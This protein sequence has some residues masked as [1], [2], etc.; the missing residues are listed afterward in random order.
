MATL[1]SSAQFLVE[2]FAATFTLD[3][4]PTAEL[5]VC[6]TP[7]TRLTA[8]SVHTSTLRDSMWCRRSGSVYPVS[9]SATRHDDGRQHVLRQ[10]AYGGPAFDFIVSREDLPSGF[11]VPGSFANYPWYYMRRVIPRRLRGQQR[12]PLLTKRCRRI[13]PARRRSR[14]RR[15]RSGRS[16]HSSARESSARTGL[17]LRRGDHHFE[18]R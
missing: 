15:D 3:A 6:T 16:V 7:L 12:W 5:P 4:H 18:P 1:G 9:V 14:V 8:P 13:A 2:E 10:P 11:C 17:W